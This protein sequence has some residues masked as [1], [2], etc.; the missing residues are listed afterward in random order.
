MDITNTDAII[1]RINELIY[2]M[3]D[4]PSA[5]A[6]IVGPGFPLTGRGTPGQA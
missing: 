6:K 1:S 5:F 4:N 3:S 2:S